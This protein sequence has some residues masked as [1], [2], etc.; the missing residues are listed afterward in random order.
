MG[1]YRPLSNVSGN[2]SKRA[3]AIAIQQYKNIISYQL[4]S[5]IYV[6]IYFLDYS[7][8]YDISVGSQLYGNNLHIELQLYCFLAI[9]IAT[10]PKYHALVIAKHLA[11]Y[12]QLYLATC[13]VVNNY[14]YIAIYSTL[15]EFQSLVQ[16]YTCQ[17]SFIQL[18][19][20]FFHCTFRIFIDIGADCI[21]KLI[22]IHDTW[23]YIKH[24]RTIQQIMEKFHSLFHWTMYLKL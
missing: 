16:L 18:S 23:L 11:I 12:V 2:R 4:Y 17:L 24:Q 8:I 3:T 6:T 1:L 5:Y 20:K 13:I 7:Y 21:E 14:M 9:A 10:K 15:M 22:I 19:T